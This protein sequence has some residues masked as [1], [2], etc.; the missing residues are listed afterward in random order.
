MRHEISLLLVV[1]LLGAGAGLAALGG[2]SSEPP[3]GPAAKGGSGELT[4]AVIPKGTS[5]EFWKTI[6]AGAAKAEREEKGVKII[7]KGPVTEDD[8][9]AQIEVVETFT[10]K[11]VDGIVVAP[12]DNQALVRPIRAA[13]DAGITVVIIDSDLKD[14]DAYTSF[15]ATDNTK[16]GVLAAQ[17]MA[18]VLGAKGG[19]VILLRYQVGSASTENRE[20]GF[21]DEIAKHDAIKIISKEQ[22]AGATTES[23]MSASET[24]LVKFGEGEV[25]GIFCPNESS[26]YGML[27]AL[28]SAKRAGKVAFIGFDSSPKLIDALEKGEMQGTIVQ[29]P[30]TMGYMGV[31]T[32]VAALRGTKVE[33]RID[34]GCTVVTPENLKDP[35]IH[36][37]LYPPV[38]EF[39]NE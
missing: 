25:D 11:R 3:A 24:L 37:L 36:E 2:C 14:P 32:C 13:H 33:K 26:A 10:A 8:R 18:E 12:L 19:K 17:R 22:Y 28:R 16:G 30:F 15:V 27:Q 9:A 5:H 38:K 1:I 31:K 7:W 35:K 39:L 34:T 21:L 6:H 23:A 29:N 4:L 20:K